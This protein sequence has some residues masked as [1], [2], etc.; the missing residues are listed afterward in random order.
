MTGRKRILFVDDEPNVLEGLRRSLSRMRKQWDMVLVNGGRE[1][2][3]LLSTDHFDAV[4]SDMKMPEMNGAELLTEIGMLYPHMVRF[5]L[6]GQPDDETIIKAVRCSHQYLSKPCNTGKLC[7][8]LARALTLVDLL[9]EIGL[10]GKVVGP[11]NLPCLPEILDEF[12]SELKGGSLETV[13]LASIASRDPGLAV[14]ML[15]LA[16]SSYFGS[17][18]LI[19]TVGKAVDIIGRHTLAK[20]VKQGD[21]FSAYTREAVK[22]HGLREK[23]ERS[24]RYGE[25]S[26]FVARQMG[27]EK[28]LEECA[29][30]LGLLIDVGEFLLISI[31]PEKSLES[32][33]QEQALTM[34]SIEAERKLYGVS[35]DEVGACFLG[36]PGLPDMLVDAIRY[37][38]CPEAVEH[39]NRLLTCV[40]AAEGLYREL[41]LGEKDWLESGSPGATLPDVRDGFRQ[42]SDQA[43]SGREEMATV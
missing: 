32:I 8:S 38:H 28:D 43:A 41:V 21:I 42:W 23:V 3:D 13:D 5:V 16:N 31:Y 9:P 22:M 20:L 15:H 29:Y 2:L 36:L 40:C 34:D 10:R 39:E 1:A 30:A 14:K 6:S 25:Y 37:H 19:S 17:L 24:V 11:G 18:S 35:H 27:L 7:E 26:V 12:C 33:T 4:V